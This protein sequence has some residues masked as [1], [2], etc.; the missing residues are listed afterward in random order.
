[1]KID[2]QTRE[3]VRRL[4]KTWREDSY[5]D[6]GTRNELAGLSEEEITDRFYTDLNFG[7][8]GLRGLIG[9]G[10]NRMNIYVVRKV[11]QA[12]SDIIREEG[13][14]ACARGVVIAYDSRYLA[15]VFAWETARVLAA[16]NIRSYLFDALRP[17]PELS[18]AVRYLG[19]MAGVMI[20][21]S[22]N[23]REHNGYKVYWEDGSQIGVEKAEQIGR[24]MRARSSWAVDVPANGT[25]EERWPTRIGA[26]IDEAFRNAVAQTLVNPDLIRRR[27][28][29]LSIVY[30]P[31]HGTGNLPTRQM[32]HQV[33]FT[34]VHVVPE[35]EQP[36][37]SFPTV[38]VPN[39]E[40]PAALTMALALA[41]NLQ[42][43]IVL[44]SDPDADRLGLSVRDKT[45]TYRVFTGNQIGILLSH[46]LIGQKSAQGTL[47][48]D[49]VVIK[50]V[51]S[52]DLVETIAAEAGLQTR[53]VHV[54]FRFI[55][56]QILEMET[57]GSG[58]FLFGFE[59]SLGY[60]AGT[61]ARDKD[62]V[63]A[64]VLLSEAALYYK[65]IRGQSL[66]EVLQD[67]YTRYGYYEDAQ[68]SVT[69]SGIA[70]RRRI[71]EIMTRMRSNPPRTL[72]GCP[73]AKIEDY[74][75]RR[76]QHVLTATE[77]PID[78]PSA[79]VLRF[80]LLGGG[81]VLVR[82]SGTEP[83]IKFYF[84]LKS[85]DRASGQEFLARVA[86][87]FLAPVEDLLQG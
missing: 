58:R 62:A 85:P 33:G 8:A 57:T 43:D 79:D 17:A 34:A 18:F 74:Q 24:Y 47:A 28:G 12:L 32:L 9:A 23:P 86:K 4:H 14:E 54:G 82:P 50:T 52:T 40:D 84:S 65:V 83:K 22:H 87:E 36:D 77:S 60:L 5:F 26:E 78:L 3:R 15:N 68:S 38:R 61:Y 64:A 37:G 16:N 59:E 6:E 56:E 13:P 67:I 55:G 71:E 70:G 10:T 21:A 11:T 72:A 45:G 31:L 76:A 7:T 20:T 75:A 81:Y 63:G 51:A 1:M 48:Q 42:A 29:E 69:L 35:Q 41:Q 66:W 39:P 25:W 73:I 53:N 27:G 80:S 49:A 19:C 44:V 2:A 30:S 46:Y